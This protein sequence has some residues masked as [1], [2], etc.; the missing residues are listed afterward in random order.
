MDEIWDRRISAYLNAIF[1][2]SSHIFDGFVKNNRMKIKNQ[3][4]HP[5][6]CIQESEIRGKIRSNLDILSLSNC[7]IGMAYPSWQVIKHCIPS[8]PLIQSLCPLDGSGRDSQRESAIKI[9]ILAT[10]I[11]YICFTL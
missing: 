3:V 1:V 7:E 10:N 2:N 4:A 8:S 9:I 5:N 6:E 11:L